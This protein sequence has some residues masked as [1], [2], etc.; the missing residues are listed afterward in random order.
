MACFHAVMQPSEVRQQVGR[1]S[2]GCTREGHLA[3]PNFGSGRQ[4]LNLP[5]VAGAWGNI[6][7][8]RPGRS[9]KQ[10]LQEPPW[11]DHVFLLDLSFPLRP[12]WRGLSHAAER[13][14]LLVQGP[15]RSFR[16]HAGVG[17]AGVVKALLRN[18]GLYPPVDA[19][20]LLFQV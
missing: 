7:G 5:V 12:A 14:L 17:V 15:Q 11:A 3:R 13:D 4:P 16:L 6:V 1:T 18:P 20:H 8:K 2:D 19:G 10:D 9:A